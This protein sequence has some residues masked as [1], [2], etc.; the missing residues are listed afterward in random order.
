LWL[1]NRTKIRTG[2]ALEAAAAASAP[3]PSR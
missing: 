3:G 2:L 1:T